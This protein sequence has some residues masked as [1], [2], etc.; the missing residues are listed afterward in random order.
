MHIRYFCSSMVKAKRR[1]AIEEV[2]S[3]NDEHC[4]AVDGI[5]Y[6]TVFYVTLF[7]Q[8]FSFLATN[9]N[10]PVKVECPNYVIEKAKSSR[11]ECK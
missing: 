9:D 11:A 2:A 5:V 10:M 1:A 4:I 3:D 7:L 6:A 8:A